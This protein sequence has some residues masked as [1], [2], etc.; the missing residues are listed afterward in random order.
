MEV[1]DVIMDNSTEHSRRGHSEDK[2][3]TQTAMDNDHMITAVDSRA[4]VLEQQEAQEQG[5]Q[6]L[7][8]AD[9]VTENSR[10]EMLLAM[11]IHLT[12]MEDTRDSASKSRYEIINLN[13]TEA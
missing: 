10:V 4:M 11:D 3:A 7:A 1:A 12:L 2:E 9:S 8:P 5:V 6:V 13:S